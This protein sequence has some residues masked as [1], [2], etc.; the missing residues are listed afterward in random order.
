MFKVYSFY[1]E[2]AERNRVIPILYFLYV[3][4][5]NDVRRAVTKIHS[6]HNLSL[7]SCIQSRTVLL[8]K[9]RFVRWK[10]W[11]FFRFLSSV[12]AREILDVLSRLLLLNCEIVSSFRVT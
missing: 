4:R 3:R 10:Q 8:A 5:T 1:F 2:I 7:A 6:Y 12:L 11:K 9:V